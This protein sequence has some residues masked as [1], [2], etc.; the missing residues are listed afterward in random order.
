MDS[1]HQNSLLAPMSVQMHRILLSAELIQFVRAGFVW[2]RITEQLEVLTKN[3]CQ[4]ESKGAF[5]KVCRS[6][7]PE[8][9]LSSPPPQASAKKAN[10]LICIVSPWSPSHSLQWRGIPI[11]KRKHILAFGYLNSGHFRS[12]D[13]GCSV[14]GVQAGISLLPLHFIPSNFPT[15]SMRFQAF[16]TVLQQLHSSG[17]I[18][19]LPSEEWF[20]G[21]KI[22]KNKLFMDSEAQWWHLPLPR[23]EGSQ[24]HLVGLNI[25][26][27]F[28]SVGDCIAKTRGILGINEHQGCLFTYP[29]FST[30]VV[31]LICG[32][33]AALLGLW[34]FPVA[35]P[36]PLW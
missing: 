13:P 29:W 2:W 22:N 26:G 30:S 5:G 36:Q 21:I 33:W 18:V 9:F 8:D 20:Q 11:V 4:I 12:M 3:S 19:P 14:P 32:K 7:V 35:C 16:Q 6:C 34:L 24:H 28:S 17:M 15:L 27:G 25:P 1:L 10:S 23:L 31:S